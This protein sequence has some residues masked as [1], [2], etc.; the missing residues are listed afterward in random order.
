M[1]PAQHLRQRKPPPLRL[2]NNR[3]MGKKFPINPAHPERSCWGCDRYCAADS[4]ICGNGTE[5]TQH[6]VELFGPGWEG[7]GLDPVR[8]AE[9]SAPPPTPR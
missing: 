7:F 6:P 1:V 4:M 9:P 3:G 5:R 8:P 2:P